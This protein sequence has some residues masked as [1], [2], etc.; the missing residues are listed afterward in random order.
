M[1]LQFAGTQGSGSDTW[2]H[3]CDR[4]WLNGVRPLLISLVFLPVPVTP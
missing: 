2:S 4:E 1:N 3:F